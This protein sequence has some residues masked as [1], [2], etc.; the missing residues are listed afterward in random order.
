MKNPTLLQWHIY[1][2]LTQKVL[3]VDDISIQFFFI[4]VIYA[5]QCLIGFKECIFSL[6]PPCNK[7]FTF[8]N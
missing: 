4:K 8:L 3:N 5:A 7:K 2:Y 6:I 1:H